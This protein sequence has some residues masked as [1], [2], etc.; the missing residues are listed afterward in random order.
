MKQKIFLALISILCSLA[1]AHI[2]HAY[3]GEYS[4]DPLYIE[5]VET[6]LQRYEKQLEQIDNKLDESRKQLEKYKNETNNL[7]NQYSGNNYSYC[8]ELYCANKDLANP[9]TN[10]E[11]LALLEYC[12]ATR[13]NIQKPSCAT[14]YIEYGGS[15][16]SYDSVC[17]KSYGTNSYSTGRFNS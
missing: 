1:Y 13:P 11:C 3:P 4:W 17:K 9:Y 8:Y 2:T 10:K 14:G 7:S 5:I 6:P 12:L 16:L 15:C